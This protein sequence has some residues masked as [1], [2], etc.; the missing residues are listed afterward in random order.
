MSSGL[1]YYLLTNKH[2]TEINGI[3]QADSLMQI[4]F[5]DSIRVLK[6]NI[7]SLKSLP[8]KIIVK[9]VTITLPGGGTQTIYDTLYVYPFGEDVKRE[10]FRTTNT[11]YDKSITVFGKNTIESNVI[12]Y[13]DTTLKEWYITNDLLFQQDSLSVFVDSSLFKRFNR[14]QWLVGMAGGRRYN[15]DKSAIDIQISGGAIY[16]NKF[17][18]GIY[19]SP[20]AIGIETKFNLTEMFRK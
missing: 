13:A 19:A 5:K 15:D 2:Q 11:F 7:D 3:H 16:N 9:T 20:N 4:A 14:F 1:T 6:T 17:Y 10:T 8:P 18:G 12:V